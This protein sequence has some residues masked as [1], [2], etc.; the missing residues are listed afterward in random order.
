[1]KKLV[2]ANDFEAISA[3]LSD[4]PAAARMRSKDGKGPLWWAYSGRKTEKLIELFK[5][6]GARDDERD[7]GGKRPI[8]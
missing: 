1:M 2:K 8:D 3:W 5:K 4:D 6:L 7:A